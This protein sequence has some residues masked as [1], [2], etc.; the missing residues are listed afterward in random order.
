MPAVKLVKGRETARFDAW[1]D[2]PE[3]AFRKLHDEID[4][5]ERVMPTFNTVSA[6]HNILEAHGRFYATALVIIQETPVRT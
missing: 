4:R 3:E 1:G 2:T 5:I 6:S